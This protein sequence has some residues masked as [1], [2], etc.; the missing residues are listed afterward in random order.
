MRGRPTAHRFVPELISRV[1]DTTELGRKRGDEGQRLRGQDDLGPCGAVTGV[2][3]LWDGSPRGFARA[4]P[5]GHE[6]RAPHQATVRVV[7][8]AVHASGVGVQVAVGLG[9]LTA[10]RLT[11]HRADRLTPTRPHRTERGTGSQ[12]A[13]P[14]VGRAGPAHLT[15]LQHDFPPRTP[16]RRGQESRAGATTSAWGLRE[17]IASNERRTAG[18]RLPR[19]PI[20]LTATHGDPCGPRPRATRLVRSAAD[21]CVPTADRP[22]LQ[23]RLGPSSSPDGL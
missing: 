2:L 17:R 12:R 9:S 16:C 3:P 1:T 7:G 11:S 6:L 4:S 23:T 19:R 13:P 20:V 21:N 5:F 18:K 22:R 10:S 15:G 14:H 8:A